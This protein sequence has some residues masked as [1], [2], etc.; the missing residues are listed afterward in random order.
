MKTDMTTPST[1]ET[2][3]EFQSNSPKL[4]SLLALASAAVA[5]PQTGNAD[6]V[7]TDLNSAPAQVGFLGGTTSFQFTLPGTALFGFQRFSRTVTTT[8]PFTTTH[9]FRTVVA[10]DLYGGVPAFIQVAPGGFAAPLTYGAPW[11]QGLTSVYTAA[12]GVANSLGHS[13]VN[14]YDHQYLAW[15]FVDSSAGNAVRYGWIEVGLS[16][17]NVN[18]TGTSGG[19][20]VTIYGYAYDNTPGAKPTMGQRPV[21]EP[22]SAAL[23][24]VGAMA[25]GARGV[26]NWRQNRESAGKS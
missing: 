19:P 13:P 15:S 12:M 17:V 9:F 5:M 21:P 14:S 6:I 25:L 2:L 23:L 8:S 1:T 26:R 10:R 22:S 4:A 7:Y 11:D 24:I 3:N 20:N 18:F 16:I